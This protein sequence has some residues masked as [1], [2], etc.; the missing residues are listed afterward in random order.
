[1]KRVLQISLFFITFIS[2]SQTQVGVVQFN[3]V[4]MFNK[5]ELVLNGAAEREKL[6]AIALYLDLDFD[7]DALEDGN[8]V[9]EKD[10]TMAVTIKIISNGVTQE[11]LKNLVRIGLE[12]A[13]DGNSY[14]FE[15]QIRDFLNFIPNEINKFDIFR[16]LYTKG[17]K[18][19]LF[20]NKEIK[21]TIDNSV[22]F[23]KA[24]FK[25][26]LGENPV[27]EN[28]KDDL[29]GSS[30]TNLVLGKWKTYDKKTG[31]AISIIQIYMIDNAVYGTIER[32]LRNS[33]RD[34]VCFEC[35]GEDKNKKVEGL[36]ILKK[37]R[38]K[39]ENKYAGGQF[40]NIKTGKVTD[41]QVW[42]EEDDTDVLNVKYKGGGGTQQW[43][44]VK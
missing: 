3:D 26:W 13:T 10:E 15:E 14:V 30:D 41:C 25:V 6:Y 2:F 38:Q 18:L 1:M 17:G 16:I 40:T 7:L 29:L 11:D 33:E 28:V 31:V 23:K 21:G 44:R 42:I 4:D 20:E 27:D 39:S 12:R 43:K 35:E 8:K 9:A 5:T 36:V 19:T 34:D 22:D 37:L 24:L 32:M